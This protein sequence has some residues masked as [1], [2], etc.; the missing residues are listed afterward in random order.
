MRISQTARI[1]QACGKVKVLKSKKIE[2][3]GLKAG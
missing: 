2:I 1:G 3:G